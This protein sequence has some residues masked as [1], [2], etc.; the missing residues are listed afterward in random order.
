[1]KVICFD[2]DDTLFKERLY[3]FSA[4]RE[5]VAYAVSKISFPTETTLPESAYEVMVDTYERGKNAFEALNTLLGL[6]VLTSDYL[7][8][9]RNHVPDIQLPTATEELLWT[10]LKQGHVLGLITDGRS[11]QQRH[12]IEALGLERFFLPENIVISE[13]F[14]SEKPSEINYR[15]FLNRYPEAENF[16]YVGDN[17]K[18]DFVTPNRLGWLTVGL[19]DNGENIH[20]QSMDFLNEFLPKYW[21]SELKQLLKLI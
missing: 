6:Q 3:L 2:L 8:L 21:I 5:I 10:L 17:P 20:S 12:K 7:Q 11:I 19:K 1:M 4:Y 18:K 13:E 15:Y 16:L 9:Y 14:G